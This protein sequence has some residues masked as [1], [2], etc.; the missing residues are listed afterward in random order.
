[1]LGTFRLRGCTCKKKRCTCGAKWYFRYDAG[2]DPKTGERRQREKGGFRTKGEAEEAA[3][4]IFI[5][6]SQGIHIQEKN[7]TFKDFATQWI[8]LYAATGKVKPSTVD[9]RQV[10]LTRILLYFSKIKLKDVTKLMYQDMLN[11]LSTRYA[12][13]TVSST[14]EAGSLL[15][16]KAVEFEIISTDITKSAQ[17]PNIQQTVADLEG[18]IEIPKYLEKEELSLFLGHTKDAK[19]PAVHAAFITLAYT[20]L[21]VGELCAL[22]WKDIDYVNQTISVTKTIYNKKSNVLEY[23]LQTPKTKSSRR[24][25][26]VDPFVLEVLEKHR[27]RQNVIRLACGEVYLKERFVFANTKNFPGYPLTIYTLNVWMRKL[28]RL[29]GLNPKLAPHS[30]RHTHTSLLAEAGVSLETIM[31]RLG[32][33]NDAIT[34]N[35]YLHVTK[36]RKKEA[37]QKFAELMKSI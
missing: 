19:N 21:R 27:A 13:K 7:V 31:D 3:K 20:G 14:H 17:L 2:P 36:P 34:R 11:A 30:L 6:I 24:T 16:K 9:M 5:E 8:K 37:S 26:D 1:M 10:Q 18:R 25:I 35:V 29:S 22:K 28:L 15:F 12:R 33:Q 4:K 32:H 23:T